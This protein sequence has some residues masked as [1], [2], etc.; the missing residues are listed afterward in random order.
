MT[1]HRFTGLDSLFDI[2]LA[3]QTLTASDASTVD[4]TYG[5]EESDVINNLRT[6]L[7]ELETILQNMGLIG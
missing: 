3:S 1:D 6:R 2:K 5:T 4:V 7:D